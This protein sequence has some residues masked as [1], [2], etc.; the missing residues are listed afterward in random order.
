M[1]SLKL[2]A[3]E[4][5]ALSNKAMNKIYG[6]VAVAGCTCDCACAWAGK[7]GSSTGDNH[8]ANLC[9]ADGGPVSTHIKSTVI[10]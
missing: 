6:G 4:A 8:Y 7:G 2:T 3:L 5:D 9:K 1:K 10:N